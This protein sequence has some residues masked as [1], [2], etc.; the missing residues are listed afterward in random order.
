MLLKG[1]FE[2]FLL[3]FLTHSSNETIQVKQLRDLLK[4]NFGNWALCFDLINGNPLL[5]DEE[6]LIKNLLKETDLRKAIS[7]MKLS[8]FFVH[9]YSSYLFNLVLS[10]NLGND[11][12]NVSFEKLGNSSNNDKLNQNAFSRIFKKEGLSVEDF[13]QQGKLFEI[14]NHSRKAVFYP[15]NFNYTFESND[16]VVS[17]ELGNGEYASLVL[18]FLF[19]NA[20]GK[21]N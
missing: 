21:L 9:A 18:G 3:N 6:E 16:L 8:N 11:L 5:K 20:F 14:K 15:N 19:E 10:E 1:E 13:S 17:F 2:E 7:E 12:N 4:A